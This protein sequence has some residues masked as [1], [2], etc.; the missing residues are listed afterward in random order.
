MEAKEVLDEICATICRLECMKPSQRRAVALWC[1]LTYL[2]DAVD[3]LPL[4]LITSPEENCGKT[5]LLKLV[6]YLGNRPVPA[7]NV[8][9]AAIFRTIKD[10]APTMTLDEADTYLQDNAE[11]RGVIDWATN[12]NSL[13]SFVPKGKAR[14]PVTFQR[15]ARKR[16]P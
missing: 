5:T 4:L 3:I 9:A 10:I 6:L 7:G 15:G 1:V 2:H 12:A 14:K 13:G 8:S 16:L 11:M